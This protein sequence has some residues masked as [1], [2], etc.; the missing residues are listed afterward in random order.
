MKDRKKVLIWFPIN[1][2]APV[3]GPAGY[4][5]NLKDRLENECLEFVFL[6]E[7]TYVKND[8]NNIK[9]ILRKKMKFFLDIYTI[10]NIIKYFYDEIEDI[11]QYDMIHFHNTRDLYWARHILKKFKGKV[12]LTSHSPKPFHLEVLEDDL[13]VSKLQK[14]VF[15]EVIEKFDEFD[16]YAFNR[17]DFIVFPCKEAEEPYLNNWKW[18]N[19]FSEKNRKKYIYIPSCIEKVK[20]KHEKEYI[21]D[22][23]SIPKDAKV[24]CY[25][26][27]HN[28]TKGYDRLK[29]IS[30]K[31]FESHPN[32][33]ILIAGKE[34]PLKG[35]NH[36][37]WIEVGW[38]NDPYSIINAADIFVL[39][40]KETYFDLIL[41]E[42]LS[43]GKVV[44]ASH[45]GGNKY[46]KKYEQKGIFYFENE[47]DAIKQIDSLINLSDNELIE[48]GNK[49][50]VLFQ[51]NFMT[52]NFISEYIKEINKII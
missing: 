45:T 42:V 20:V 3:G 6:P 15:K 25:V 38:T 7:E 4:L 35:L 24:I 16:K 48:L 13:R 21:R 5:Y 28:E 29:K 41:L 19:K 34:T 51:Y 50:K 37:R 43:L 47:S 23:Y 49:N 17:A 1:K 36:P 18:Y 14:K 27:R 26:G 12:L 22:K 40:N 31:V 8:L 46:F 9:K 44:L 2:V 32:I 11:N 39:P 10:K 52:T 33:F 30:E